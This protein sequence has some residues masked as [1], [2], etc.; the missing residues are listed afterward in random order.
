[1]RVKP[2]G[3][4]SIAARPPENVPRLSKAP[5]VNSRRNVMPVLQL[6]V[7]RS[8]QGLGEQHA[9]LN[10]ELLPSIRLVRELRWRLQSQAL[11]GFGQHRSGAFDFEVVVVSSRPKKII[12]E[13]FDGGQ[14]DSISVG[15][16]IKDATSVSNANRRVRNTEKA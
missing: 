14:N 13:S 9:V 15:A 11:V 3:F 8:L 2:F 7:H 12:V 10:D 4:S 5:D 16:E 6:E 1:M